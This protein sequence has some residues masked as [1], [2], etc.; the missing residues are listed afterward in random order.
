MKKALAISLLVIGNLAA[1]CALSLIYYFVFPRIFNLVLTIL[2]GLAAVVAV[3]CASSRLLFPIFER[4]YRL[5]S[6]LFVLFA[7]VPPIIG[8]AGYWIVYLILDATG[9]FKGKGW[10]A[11]VPG[12]FFGLF[13]GI[14]AMAYL[15]SGD[16]WVSSV[17]SR[18]NANR[19]PK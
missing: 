13:L 12:A 4:K 16:A 17:T 15:I 7:H 1:V 2:I 5:N 6:G 11:D 9:Y 18:S 10:F 3:T 14:T 8:T 19:S